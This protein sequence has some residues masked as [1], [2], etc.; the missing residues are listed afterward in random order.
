M[1]ERIRYF[2]ILK[3]IAI[4]WVVT[5]HVIA[6]GAPEAESRSFLTMC[7][8][9]MPVFFFIS[10]W[11]TALSDHKPHAFFPT[12]AKRFRRLLLPGTVVALLMLWLSSDAPSDFAG[13]VRDFVADSHKR[14][15]WFV[16]VLF[17]VLLIY[18]CVRPAMNRIRSFAGRVV[19]AAAVWALMWLVCV[20]LW[21][22]RLTLSLVLLCRYLPLFLF[23]ALA[24]RYS[25]AF[26]AL[27]SRGAFVGLCLVAVAVWT[28][29]A[30]EG[31]WAGARWA[32]LLRTAAE[33]GVVPVA[34][35]AGRSLAAAAVSG[36][37]ALR[38]CIGV[39]EYMG[40]RSLA[41]Y[42]L[43]YF[44]VFPFGAG[45]AIPADTGFA[46]VPVAVMGVGT[47]VCIIAVV[48]LIDYILSFSR[49]LSLLLTGGGTDPK[50]LAVK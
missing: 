31:L 37:A 39:L 16:F 22:L 23:G 4:L 11:L 46:L 8:A 14:G 47:A 50:P 10:G 25:D 27:C 18:D 35:C 17:G 20:V 19:L 13:A 32:L 33:F 42:L 30:C 7:P 43:H 15:Y 44:F 36:S 34:V 41:I 38:R 21:D 28:V 49:P 3:G 5:L 9:R 48:L 24:A 45:A 2:D 1:K 12:L 40:H 6:W 26:Y 29:G